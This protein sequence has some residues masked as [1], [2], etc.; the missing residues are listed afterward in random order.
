MLRVLDHSP[1]RP[2]FSETKGANGSMSRA[3]VRTFEHTHQHRR[4]IVCGDHQDVEIVLLQHAAGARL[5]SPENTRR[6][7]TPQPKQE[8]PAQKDGVIQPTSF[9]VWAK[10]LE[11][12]EL[13]IPP[14]LLACADE[15]HRVKRREFIT[16]GGATDARRTGPEGPRLTPTRRVVGLLAQLPVLLFSWMWPIIGWGIDLQIHSCIVIVFP[17]RQCRKHDQRPQ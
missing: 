9:P 12:S 14:T 1:C 3:W 11:H 4:M 2:P 6:P 10:Q 15:D 13:T 7:V 16:L 5:G 17:D 8:M